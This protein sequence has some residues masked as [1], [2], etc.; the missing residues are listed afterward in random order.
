MARRSGCKREL[1]DQQVI[2][3]LARRGEQQERHLA[4][5]GS[6]RRVLVGLRVA[7]LAT[8]GETRPPH[9]L[10]EQF[11][12]AASQS[13][14][15]MHRPLDSEEARG[16]SC[17]LI[18]CPCDRVSRSS[19]SSSLR[20]LR[21][22]LWRPRASSLSRGR[23]MSRHDRLAACRICSKRVWGCRVAPQVTRRAARD[24]ARA[25][26][27]YPAAA[28]CRSCCFPRRARPWM[29]WLS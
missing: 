2:Q 10:F 24:P 17:W 22:G 6:P 25:R 7:R 4:A 13:W 18:W 26:R 3:G 11:R 20:F 16:R 28:K 15:D 1:Y 12:H 14:R 19:N 5:A 29:T 9:I 27:G 8:C 21:L 23:C